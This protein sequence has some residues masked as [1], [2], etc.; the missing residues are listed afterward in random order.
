MSRLFMTGASGFI[1]NELAEIA[2]SGGH[3]IC[4]FDIAPP[5]DDK[6]AFWIEGDVRDAD[7]LARAMY[8]FA[9]DYVVHLASDT[10]VS[11]VDLE[12]FTVTLDGTRNV[13]AAVAGLPSLQRFVH[14]STQFAVRPGIAPPD[15]AYLEPYTVYG[16]AKAETER[17][18]RGA[19]LSVPWLIVRPTIIW[20]PRHPSFSKN[21]FRYIRSR[22]YMH[23]VGLGPI[24]RAFGYVT[25]TAS[26]IYA[27]T[28]S[29]EA[30]IRRKVYY[31]GD[32]AL[33]YARWA[34]AFSIGLTGKKAR[35]LPVP[36]LKAM[37]LAGDFA[38]RLGLPAPIDSGRAFRMSTPS[39]VDLQPILDL[40]GPP[41]I[42]FDEGVAHTIAWLNAD[43][44][45][46][47]Q[48]EASR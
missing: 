6:R 12:Q 42:G 37:G 47:A 22:K 20:G 32:E 34:D 5:T 24:R 8:N 9:P 26:Q 35:R 21:I 39:Q 46:I 23:P 4:N 40:A 2:V 43:T 14:I 33:D 48:Q 3:T 15:D 16:Q 31:V 11:I 29:D 19:K 13:V 30:N 7:A 45:R 28:L 36:L 17:I 27:L 38:K 10:D 44:D 18:V 41:A 25:N 1:G